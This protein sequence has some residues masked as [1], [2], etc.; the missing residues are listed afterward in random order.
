MRAWRRYSLERSGVR[1]ENAR[2]RHR[3]HRHERWLR[4]LA[5]AL[6]NAPTS[7]EVLARSRR[8]PRPSSM[9]REH[10]QWALAE[11]ARSS[12]RQQAA[13]VGLKKCRPRRVLVISVNNN[14]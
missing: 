8:G 5:V 1:G 3:P 6:G 13:P 9:V 10:V 14:W 4:N 2:Q 11:H 12:R 7:A